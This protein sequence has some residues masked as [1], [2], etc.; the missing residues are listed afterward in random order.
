MMRWKYEKVLHE[1]YLRKRVGQI[2]YLNNLQVRKDR[3]GVKFLDRHC[4]VKFSLA[5]LCFCGNFFVMLL[6]VYIQWMGKFYITKRLRIANPL[7]N[8]EVVCA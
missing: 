5:V 6:H 1:R 7:P 3:T 8:L 4:H 2:V